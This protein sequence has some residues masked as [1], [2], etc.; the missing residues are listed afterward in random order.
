[1]PVR[2]C[3]VRLTDSVRSPVNS[4]QHTRW[5]ERTHVAEETAG[6]GRWGGS[7]RGAGGE[8]GGGGEAAGGGRRRQGADREVA[9][10]RGVRGHRGGGGQAGQGVRGVPREQ[11]QSAGGDGD[12]GD[13]RAERL[14]QGRG[15]P[16]RG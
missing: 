1:M 5:K 9:A 12:L 7:G 4:C 10:A 6:R 2:R 8:G 13:L 15:R 3:V 11:G 14:D 16:A